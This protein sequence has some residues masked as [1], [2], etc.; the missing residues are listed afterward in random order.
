MAELLP[1][2]NG[3]TTR[4]ST[5]E[6]DIIAASS[7]GFVGLEL[8]TWKLDNYLRNH[9]V[10]ELKTIV[11]DHGLKVPTLGPYEMVVLG[12]ATQ[13]QASLEK[14]K[15]H[16]EIAAYLGVQG[17][18]FSFDEPRNESVDHNKPF[19]S[20][21]EVAIEYAETIMPLNLLCG[22]ESLGGQKTIRGPLELMEIINRATVSNIRIVFDTFQFY[23]NQT[24][25]QGITSIPEELILIL[26]VSDCENLPL[27][28]LEDKHRLY[29]GL[30][31]IPLVD[32]LKP[33]I[34]KGYNRFISIEVTRPEYATSSP[35]EICPVAMRYLQELIKKL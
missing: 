10:S 20:F 16:A 8:K 17:L 25:V 31:I 32:L 9:S 14:V 5:M 34:D 27:Q 4:Y 22:I 33:V 15:R 13:K 26:H 12:S 1:A 19:D 3:T 28:N 6:E 11:E 23:R 2:Y 21:I 24:T 7:A 29:P 30:G 35:H 18:A